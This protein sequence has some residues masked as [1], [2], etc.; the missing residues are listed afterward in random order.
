MSR[1][2]IIRPDVTFD[3]V[4]DDLRAVLD[5]G[6]LT[7]GPYLEAFEAALAATV[8]TRHAVATT[9]ATTALHL[10]LHAAGVGPGDEVLTSDFT[11]PATGNVIVQLGARPVLVDSGRDTFALDPVDAAAKV[12]PRT[13]A[14]VPVDPFGQPADADRLLAIAVEHD[15]VVVEDAACGLGA[16]GQEWNCGEWPV[17]GCFSFH[18]RKVVTTGEGGAITTDDDALAERLRR[19]RSHGSQRTERALAFVDHG[20]NYRLS[21]V[22]AVLGLAQLGRLDAILADRAATAAAYDQRLAGVDGIEVRRPEPGTRWSHQSY[23]VMVADDV[24][25]DAV[26]AGLAER[27]IESTLGTYALHAQRAFA[28]T[29]YRAGDLPNAWR[30]QRQSLTLPLVPR[31]AV[32]E[33]DRVVA[34][35]G[36]V[37]PAAR[38]DRAA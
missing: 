26:I 33:V 6:Q 32:A 30:A 9:S 15:L 23:V 11:F 19:L 8:G 31:M 14:I 27:E 22:N 21:E 3:E 38:V 20:F 5:S 18:P 34:A 25:R 13:R 7:Q 12:T 1:L 2:P 35:L 28:W 36:E 16:G 17:A 10:A 37:L 29:G 24:D 4:A